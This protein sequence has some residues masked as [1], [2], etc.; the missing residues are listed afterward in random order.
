MAASSYF[1]RKI[2]IK[3]YLLLNFVLKMVFLEILRVILEPKLGIGL[4]VGIVLN[5]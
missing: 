3:G 5:L 4:L 2:G 1:F